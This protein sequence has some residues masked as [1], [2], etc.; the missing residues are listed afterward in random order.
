LIDYKLGNKMLSGTNFN[1]I[2]HGLHKMTLEGRETGLVTGNGVNQSGG[3]NTAQAK[4]QTY[5]EHLR[6]QQI[7]ES[8]VYNAGYWKVRQVTLGYDFTRYVP[9]K[10]PVKGL[11]L[12]FVA[13]NVLIIK[14]WVDNIDPESVGYGTDAMVGLESPG[15]P[16][17]RGL[18]V[19]LNVKF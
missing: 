17:T 7:I 3:E 14:K 12:D 5:W 10:W 15:L 13:N 6:S 18:G 1:A 9:A 2:R 8:V 19:N 4:V 16:T 11:K